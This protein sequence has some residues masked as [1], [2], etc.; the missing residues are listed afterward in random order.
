MTPTSAG[1]GVSLFSHNQFRSM[2]IV[3]LAPGLHPSCSQRACKSIW[4][5]KSETVSTR[6]DRI[7]ECEP[8][9]ERL[10]FQVIF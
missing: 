8:A 4:T 10:F 7:V 5:T 2:M 6:F 1:A 3:R 9:A